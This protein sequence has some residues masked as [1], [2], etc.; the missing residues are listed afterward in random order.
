MN[1]NIQITLHKCLYLTIIWSHQRK[2]NYVL[3]TTL[4]DNYIPLGYPRKK[5]NDLRLGVLKTYF[6]IIWVSLSAAYYL[7]QLMRAVWMLAIL[8]QGGFG[9]WGNANI[10]S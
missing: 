2:V 5:L 9:A 7:F 4:W 3:F 8:E 10:E 6:P 1:V